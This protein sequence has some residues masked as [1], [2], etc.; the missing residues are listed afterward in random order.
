VLIATA[1]LI[2]AASILAVGVLISAWSSIGLL[3][4]LVVASGVYLLRRRRI[5]LDGIRSWQR[6]FREHDL[7]YRSADDVRSLHRRQMLLGGGF[8]VAVGAIGLALVL[9]QI[10]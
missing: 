4:L 5:S 2:G 9:S 1:V 10:S 8:M 3:S 6:T 7:P